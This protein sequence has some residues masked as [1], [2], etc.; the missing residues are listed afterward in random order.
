MELPEG[1]GYETIMICIDQFNK[2]VVLVSLCETD[3]QTVSS[4]FLV[5]VMSNH[6]LLVNNINDRDPRF[7]G[8]FWKELM[9]NLNTSLL[10]S[11]ASH[12]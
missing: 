10:F 4:H 12:P 9:A 2:L 7:H 11:T 5:E 3:A 8:S 6:G 1:N